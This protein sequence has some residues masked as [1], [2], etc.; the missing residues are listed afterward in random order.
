MLHHGLRLAV[1]MTTASLSMCGPWPHS[2]IGNG[3][4]GGTVSVDWHNQYLFIYRPTEESPLWFRPSF[5]KDKDKPIQPVAMYTDGGSIPQIFWSIPGLSTW[6]L[7]PAF[8]IHDYIFEVHRCGWP[9]PEV[10]K[11]T[12][13][14][15]AVVLAEVGKA[16]IQ[17]GLIRDDALDAIVWAIK[18]RYARSRWDAPPTEEQKEYCEKPPQRSKAKGVDIRVM[19]FEIPPI[20]RPRL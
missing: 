17:H 1:V 13:E 8:V 4:L 11:L 10:A 18:T 14:D 20:Q 6:G 9:D 5:F 19:E 12:F 15:S 2:D 7:G 16:L 3:R